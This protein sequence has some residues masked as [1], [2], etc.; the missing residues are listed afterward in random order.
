MTA[1]AA[2][3]ACAVAPEAAG[4]R[5][6]AGEVVHL[7]LPGIHC[8]GCIA[9]V[10]GVLTRLPG[11]RAARVNLGRRR[12]RVVTAP[13]LGAAPACAA[14]QAAGFEAHEL[15]ETTIAAG[16]DETG[17]TLLARVAVAGFAMMNVMALSVAVWS[18][19]SAATEALFHWVSAAIALPALA[20][21]AVPF[22]A[23]AWAALR[24]GRVNMDT[25]IAIA[26]VLAS[27]AS[28]HETMFGAG[29]DVWFEAALS[30]TFFL[31]AGRYLDHRARAAARSAAAE[32]TA[33]EIPR[34]TI[35]DGDERRT[36]AVGDIRPGDRLA[37]SSGARIPVDGTAEGA[38]MIDRSALTGEAE[39]VALEPGAAVC[40]GETVIGAPLVVR[41]TARAEDST[42]RRIAA[43]IEVAETG[44]HRYAGIAE[45]VARLYAPLVHGLAALAF[46][47]WFAA[48]GNLHLAIGIAI[49]VLIITCPCA[50]GLAVPAVTASVTGRL[51]REG[52]LL[53]SG[54]ALER[55]AEVDCVLLDKTGTLTEGVAA[56]PDLDAQTAGIAR[57]LALAS[58][59]PV[60]RGVAG[61]LAGDASADVADIR[62][63]PGEGIH[64]RW[65]GLAVFLGRG[66]E[67]TVLHVAERVI[68]LPLSERLRPGAAG[69]VADLVRDGYDVHMVTGDNIHR[70]TRLADELG[71]AH[72]HSGLRPEGKA[73]LV[74]RMT[75]EGRRILMVGDGINDAAALS[76]AHVSMAPASALDV[77][78]VA[79]DA[80]IL[81]SDLRAVPRTL[82]ASRRALRRI[83]QN[84]WVAGGYN[85]VAIPVALAGL[86][87]PL[88]AALAMSSS[89]V[90]VVLNAVRR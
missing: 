25:P 19:A 74:A 3:P 68:A 52:V 44:R 71:I 8:A 51:F 82:A 6:A 58:D 4:V 59:H 38:A 12:V 9:G 5:D 67:G 78:R 47:G 24:A 54:S 2:C 66:E 29:A 90:S 13:G 1:L 89:S 17:R 56:L 69:M 42:L 86:A 18:G 45:R 28:L 65:R 40:A 63:V 32:L 57:A 14:L 37:L 21:A 62:E 72:V 46:A 50:L 34:A 7:S 26:I 83:R 11:V 43:L 60:A 33:L 10:E 41:A 61:A 88:V 85:A 22:F 48:T 73:E 20:F 35:L 31:L 64:G 80:V 84:L 16:T 77:A 27:A 79:S 49:A 36:I 53:K 39:P 30:L 75:A 87:S 81:A 55:F 15:D 76:Q 70:A 23:S